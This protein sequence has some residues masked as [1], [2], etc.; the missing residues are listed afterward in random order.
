MADLVSCPACQG[1]G[2][3]PLDQVADLEAA[4]LERL[5]ERG[6]AVV[7]ALEAIILEPPPEQRRSK[8]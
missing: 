5:T 3:V 1:R 8:P 6:K 2:L 4:D 7:N